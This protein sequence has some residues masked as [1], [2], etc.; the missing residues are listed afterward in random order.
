MICS[1]LVAST[2]LE[3]APLDIESLMIGSWVGTLE[4]RDFSDNSRER[5]GTLLRIFRDKSSGR[6]VLRYVYDDGPTKVVQDRDEV[7]VD[8]A[9][10]KYTVFDSTGKP[11]D[12]YSFSPPVAWNSKGKNS[13]VLSGRGTENGSAVEIR[14][15]LK[16][17]PDKLE[18][19]R[20]SRLAGQPF[21]FRHE[22]RFNRV[23][24]P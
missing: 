1:L 14:Q 7:T 12:M 16:I 10:G 13:I 18:I 3:R 20:E 22:Y 24:R 6:L 15:T 17:E 11:N 23:S 21:A 5:L 19:L 8:A 2:L 4:Y 9:S